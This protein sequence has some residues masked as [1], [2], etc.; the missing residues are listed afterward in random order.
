MVST[1]VQLKVEM[2]G[3]ILLLKPTPGL[4]TAQKSLL[5]AQHAQML[6]CLTRFGMGCFRS[7][8]VRLS[9]P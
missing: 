1:E 5:P 3:A 9:V 4:C 6:R 2:R 8:P 7:G